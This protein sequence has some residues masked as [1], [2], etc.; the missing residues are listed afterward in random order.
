METTNSNINQYLLG[1][2]ATIRVAMKQLD[3]SH[4]KVIFIVD[5]DQKLVGSV[6]DGDIR[7]WILAEGSIDDSVSKIFNR[8]TFF[9]NEND[10][11]D[12]VRKIIIEK[13][14]TAVPVCDISRNI[15]DILFWDQ[16]VDGT[17]KHRNYE[18]I[19]ANVVVM[20]GGKG[21]R[22]EPF[23]KVLPKPLIPIGD[24]TI[25]EIIIEKFVEFHIKHFFVSVNHKA[26][27][28]KSYFEEIDP[29]YTIDFIEETKPLGTIGALSLMNCDNNKPII[30]TNCDIIIDTNY[31]DFVNFHVDNKYDISL[32]ASLMNHKVPYGVCEIEKGGLLLDFKEKPEYSFL[33]STGMYIINSN[34]LEL[35]P[36]DTFFHVTDLMQIVREKGGRVG[37]FPIGEDAWL[38]TGQ[39]SEYKKT[40]DKFKL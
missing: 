13:K 11:Y 19:E 25:I 20:A 28:I 14:F 9:I 32:V 6:S 27:I 5:E 10:N 24:K 4:R 15:V 22:L 12:S 7:R 8:N 1:K 33:A 30:I 37:V 3:S 17:Q 21:T 40:I 2:E 29:E 26:K 35:I 38:D 31:A 18:L 23:T 16:V 34:L 39:W 36:K